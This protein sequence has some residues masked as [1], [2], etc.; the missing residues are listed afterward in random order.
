MSD[1]TWRNW[2]GDVVVEPA[3]VAHPASEDELAATVAAAAADGQRVKAV[4]AG[5]SFTD[6]AATDGVHLRLD[7]W[8]GLEAVDPPRGL[9]TLRAGTLL[10]EIPELLGAHGLAMENLG[11]IDRQTLAGAIATGTHGT[12][13]RFGGLATQVAAM[14]IVLADGSVV[15]CAPD[16]RPELFEAARLGLGAFGVVATITLQAVPAF[17]LQAEERP[18]R[19]SEILATFLDLAAS[20]DHVEFFWFPHTTRTLLKIDDRRPLHEGPDPLS[21][22]RAWFDDELV[23]N[24]V[25][26]AL[27]RIG[28]HVPWLV[29]SLNR[30]EGRVLSGRTYRDQSHRVFVSARRV[31]FREMEYAVPRGDVVDVVRAIQDAIERGGWRISFPIEVRTAAADD[32]WLSTAHGRPTA[33]VAVHRYWRDRP[34]PDPY[35]D[36]IERILVEA[37][38]RPHWGK[39]HT[40]DAATLAARYP[41]FD[42]ARRV[43]DTVDPERRFANAYL[44]RVLGP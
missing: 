21:P 11:D 40:Q 3:R 17:L 41:R 27:V 35:F 32:V 18:A 38:G 42:D 13:D 37:G 20:H 33:Y 8:R 7:R 1:R 24:D 31:R 39:L 25:Y 29:P 5:H 4:G 26:G 10:H 16:E 43:R 12:G 34:Q 36:T 14:T 19:L 22:R 28:H 44:D 23:A 2:S 15:R 6:I 9:A 30:L